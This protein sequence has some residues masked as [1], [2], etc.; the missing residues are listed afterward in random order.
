MYR[1]QTERPK[2]LSRHLA[3]PTLISKDLFQYQGIDIAVRVVPDLDNVEP[4]IDLAA[5]RLATEI[6]A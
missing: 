1:G 4:F 6:A 3:T 2:I 5:Q